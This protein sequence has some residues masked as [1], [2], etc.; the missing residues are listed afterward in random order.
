VTFLRLPPLLIESLD[1]LF[2]LDRRAEPWRKAAP[3]R[4]GNRPALEAE[5]GA[6]LMREHRPNSYAK[7]K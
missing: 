2:D 7:G 6:R 3:N 1:C 4:R 5:N